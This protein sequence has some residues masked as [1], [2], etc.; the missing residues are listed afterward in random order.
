MPAAKQEPEEQVRFKNDSGEVLAGVWHDSG[1]DNAVILCHGYSDTKNGFHLPA[2][3]QACAAHQYS[4]LRYCR[5][6]SVDLHV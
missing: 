4:S 2:L 3:A 5:V 1:S 6:Y